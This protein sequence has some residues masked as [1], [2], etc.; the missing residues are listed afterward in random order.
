MEPQQCNRTCRFSG[1]V[2]FSQHI[3][4]KTDHQGDKDRLAKLL[5]CVRTACT[6]QETHPRSP[7]TCL[8]AQ[9]IRSD[10]GHPLH[11]LRK[12][13]QPWNLNSATELAGSAVSLLSHNTSQK[14]LTT[15]ETKTDWPSCCTACALRAPA[16]KLTQDRLP[17]VC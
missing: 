17:P 14:K 2:A 3:T 12:P 9:Q 10:R 16:R 7:A 4:K 11:L 5:H 13:E 8:L 1:F 6:C 15:R